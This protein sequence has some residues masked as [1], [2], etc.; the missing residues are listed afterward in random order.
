[1]FSNRRLGFV[2]E[3]KKT[4]PVS[5]SSVSCSVPEIP[6]RQPYKTRKRVQQRSARLR[7]VVTITTSFTFQSNEKIIIIIITV[8]VSVLIVSDHNDVLY[9]TG[10]VRLI[11]PPL[12][13]R[14]L[15]RA[16]RERKSFRAIYFH[17]IYR[18]TV[19]HARVPPYTYEFMCIATH[20]II[21]LGCTIVVVENRECT[22]TAVRTWRSR[23]ARARW[24]GAEN[25]Y[26]RL[27]TD[28]RPDIYVRTNGGPNGV[29]GRRISAAAVAAA[30][31]RP[32]KRLRTR[33]GRSR[34]K[35]IYIYIYIC[36]NNGHPKNFWSLER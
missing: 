23:A 12:P 13:I 29:Y 14:N 30:Y 33:P 8:T 7:Y 6:R 15:V 4:T 25:V 11:K 22:P 10:N 27:L 2:V 26:P 1:M 31:R 19:V 24:K 17:D 16:C 32:R 18:Q 36:T 20:V 9:C 35:A 28:S 3:K 21:T 5:V 34:T